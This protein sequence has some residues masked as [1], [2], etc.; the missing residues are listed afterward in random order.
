MRQRATK[1]DAILS[2]HLRALFSRFSDFAGLALELPRLLT[3]ILA[4]FPRS[5]ESKV[6]ARVR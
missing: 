5:K 3:G 1:E 2:E 4:A 6:R